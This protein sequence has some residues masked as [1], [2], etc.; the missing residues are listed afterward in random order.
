MSVGAAEVLPGPGGGGGLDF[1]EVGGEIAGR[2]P[3]QLFWR[4]IR[5]D[6][7]A[8]VS[9]AFVVF[10]AIVAI[11]A[12][13]PLSSLLPVRIAVEKGV[14]SCEYRLRGDKIRPNCGEVGRLTVSNL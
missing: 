1:L 7:V 10:L 2:S 4:R 3:L 8:I 11:A 13:I 9:L 12:L 6:R 14:H 5:K